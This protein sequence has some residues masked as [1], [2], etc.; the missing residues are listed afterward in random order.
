MIIK[1]Y[2]LCGILLLLTNCNTCKKDNQPS[3]PLKCRK[4][5]KNRNEKQ[6][7]FTFNQLLVKES[8]EMAADLS[9]SSKLASNYKNLQSKI[10]V[11]AGNNKN[12]NFV[13]IEE[14]KKALRNKDGAGNGNLNKFINWAQAG[15]WEQFGPSY[16]H[17][18]WWMFPIDRSS[19]GY[20][21]QYTVY[22]N[23]IQQLKA[24]LDWLKDYRLSA[25]LLMQSWGWDV[26]NKKKYD[27]V[28]PGQQW[29]NW[30]VRLGKLIHSL[31]LFEQW[32]LYDSL[33]QYVT[34]LTQ[35]GVSVEKW[36]FDYI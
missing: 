8:Q 35:S 2:L 27:T 23:D 21:L 24:D 36:I 15:I 30:D 28:A 20:G 11:Q 32:D 18:D 14:M 19:Q 5:E 12:A 31:I 34:Y 3:I 9:T 22:Q 6:D 29:R 26:K 16:H 4:Q 7:T 25:I 33:K 13:G 17:Y 1:N 10:K